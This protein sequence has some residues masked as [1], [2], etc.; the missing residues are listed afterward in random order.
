MAGNPNTILQTNCK[1]K[2][3]YIN[4]II[5]DLM[6]CATDLLSILFGLDMQLV[7]EM[8]TLHVQQNSPKKVMY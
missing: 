7:N 8:S 4:T 1:E 5:F 2:Q 6:S 3:P